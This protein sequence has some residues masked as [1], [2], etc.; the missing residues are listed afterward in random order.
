MSC[1]RDSLS[2][3]SSNTPESLLPAAKKLR[4]SSSSLNDGEE[5]SISGRALLS[6]EA[7]DY[8][9]SICLSLLIDPVVGQC[10]HD[11]CKSCLEQWRAS[12]FNGR[13]VSCPACR[14]VAMAPGVKSLGI[15]KR[16][17]RVIEQAYP[18][19]VALRRKEIE[20][21]AVERENEKISE[22]ASQVNSVQAIMRARFSALTSAMQAASL[23]SSQ[24]A[25]VYI[26]ETQP[27]PPNRNTRSLNQMHSAPDSS[28]YPPEPRHS[29]HEPAMHLRHNADSTPATWRSVERDATAREQVAQRLVQLL[30]S[31][32]PCMEEGFKARLPRLVSKIEEGLYN[33]AKSLEEYLNPVTLEDRTQMLVRRLIGSRN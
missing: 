20:A 25:S 8:E 26:H 23:A 29:T 4:C 5:A 1:K 32:R 28:T 14:Q 33:S 3:V 22:I 7:G 17:Q 9:C 30:H 12:S 19:K 11:F 31:R 27:Q 24:Q 16:L 10:G 21:R 6:I 15:C 18:E 2:E 13:G